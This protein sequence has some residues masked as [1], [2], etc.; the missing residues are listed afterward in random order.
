MTP[1][2]PP[3]WG[4]VNNYIITI[5][6]RHGG[7]IVFIIPLLPPPIILYLFMGDNPIY[8]TET[9]QSIPPHT[10]RP[11]R[12]GGK[13]PI[14]TIHTIPHIRGIHTIHTILTTHFVLYLT[15]LLNPIQPNPVNPPIPYGDGDCLQ[16]YNTINPPWGVL[17][18]QSIPYG[19]S[20]PVNP[21][22]HPGGYCLPSP[23]YT[24]A[25]P[26]G[27]GV[28]S[29]PPT[30]QHPGG[31]WSVVQGFPLY[32]TTPKG[33][34]CTSLFPSPPPLPIRGVRCSWSVHP[35]PFPPSPL[36]PFPNGL[37]GTPTALMSVLLHNP[38][39]Q[40]SPFPPSPLPV[41]EWGW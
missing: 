12:W 41:R 28:Y 18:I 24:P 35:S 5:P 20:Y 26:S 21:P 14:Q 39:I 36:P 1:P 25:I 13:L 30:P 31:Y 16:E 3:P 11:R 9:T 10:H 17:P 37:G 2:P 33:T 8:H 7:L 22:Q 32:P 40:P 34:G 23:D 38:A 6:H 19:I 15:V 29:S 27:M 4:G